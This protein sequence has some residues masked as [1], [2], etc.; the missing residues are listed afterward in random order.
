MSTT[1]NHKWLGFAGMVAAGLAL[2]FGLP[3]VSDEFGLVQFTVFVAMA[4]LALS[5]GFIWGYGG[6]MSFGQSAFFGIGGYTYAVAVINMGD[7]TVPALLSILLPA[8]FAALLGYF[9]FYGRISDAYVGVITLT[10]TVILFNV[11]NSTAGDIY[12]IGDAQLGGFNGMP[13]VPAAQLARRSLEFAWTGRALVCQRRVL[14]FCVYVIL[15][16]H[17]GQPL[18]PRGGGDPRERDPR[19][20]ARIR[21]AALQADHLRDRRRCRRACGLRV[22]QLGWLH[23]AARVQP[24]A[25]GADHHLGPARR[26][27]H[28]ARPDPGRVRRAIPDH[29]HRRAANSSMPICCSARSWSASCCWSRKASCRPRPRCIARAFRRRPSA[30]AAAAAVEKRA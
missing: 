28:P 2:M 7:S 9:M 6:I 16:A 12:H 18:R 17:P 30:P 8:A 22:R 27:R 11:M 1:R 26:P 19:H 14:C 10:V 5:Q 3:M 21:S 23:L 25:I 4:I 15:R 20:A 24:R 29:P 13:S